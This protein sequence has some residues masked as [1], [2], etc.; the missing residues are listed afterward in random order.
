MV[1]NILIIT[2]DAATDLDGIDHVLN[3][4]FDLFNGVTSPEDVRIRTFPP[5]IA[6]V[7]ARWDAPH[8]DDRVDGFAVEF[9]GQ[10]PG[11]TVKHQ[12][13]SGLGFSNLTEYSAGRKV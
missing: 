4:Q 6:R 8:R 7:E 12:E 13:S 1:T 9:T 11:S 5:A 10:H 3:D 2:A